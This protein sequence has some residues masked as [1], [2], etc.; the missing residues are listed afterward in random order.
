MENVFVL[1]QAAI[2]AA[3]EVLL[4]DAEQKLHSRRLDV[5]RNEPDRILVKTGLNAG[6]RLVTSGVDV[7]VEGMTVRV[8]ES[9]MGAN[10]R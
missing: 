6:D 1:P 2:N 4:V 8:D 10:P 7:P 9:T 3:Q 5:L